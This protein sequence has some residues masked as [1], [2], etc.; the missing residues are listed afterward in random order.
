MLIVDGVDRS[1]DQ[2]D[3]TRVVQVEV[4]FFRTR[5]TEPTPE[6]VLDDPV[7]G[8]IFVSEDVHDPDT[9]LDAVLLGNFVAVVAIQNLGPFAIRVP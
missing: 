2:L 4:L 9:E 5:S 8:F 7:A 6:L 1:I 3:P